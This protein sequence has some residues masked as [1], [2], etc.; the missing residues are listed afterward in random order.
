MRQTVRIELQPLGQTIEVEAGAPLREVLFS[1]GV[2]FP[3]GG[4]GRCKGCRVR[5]LSGTSPAT[6]DEKQMLSPRELSDG[7][8]L[9]CR[10]QAEGNLTL[11]IA[12]WE[13]AILADETTFS[14]TPTEGLGVAVDLGTTTLVAQLLDLRSGQVRA[15]QAG[16]N[17]QA[18][19]GSDVMSRVQHALSQHG[20]VQ[21]ETLIRR[22]IGRLLSRLIISAG[23]RES[24]IADVVI[25]GNTVMHH[26]FC[27]IPVEPL[28]HVPFEPSK[29][30]LEVF[31]AR[32]LG[33][34]LPGNPRVSFLPCVGGFVGSDLLAGV[35]A[36]NLH[37][38]H[39]LLALV[40]LGTNGEIVLG[41][42]ERLLCASTAAGPAFEAGRIS[43]GMR[44][45][46]G[47]I[48][49]VRDA[50][51]ELQCTVLGDVAA[52]GICGSGLVDAVAKALGLGLIHSNGRLA[53]GRSSLQLAPGVSLTQRDIRELQLAKA[54]IAA[55]MRILLDIWGA[56]PADIRRL[57]L[58]GAFGN[59]INR[60]SARRI[61]L[62]DFPDQQIKPAGNTA[63]LGAKISL[64][65][66]RGQDDEVARIK[67]RIEH[68][69]LA[70][71]PQFQDAF[72]EGIAF[73]SEDRVEG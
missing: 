25:V 55:G 36:T 34:D 63:L 11:Q 42:R 37:L 33:W 43:C 69:S 10:V 8:R 17:P 46:T 45:T 65:A 44:A 67:S 26:L 66:S 70:A 71:H 73:P 23:V 19:H 21:L 52:R 18:T 56:R 72:V 62:L 5:L 3:C 60:A 32:D 40:D 12:Q 48:T 57:Y 28:S 31:C 29:D 51:G 27:G 2:E 54:A 38:S 61:G 16:L 6:S 15:V 41:N 39:E 30:G 64:F 68:V 13:T 49:E 47:A 59:Y 24:T 50:A 53:G 22:E 20:R 7:W 9:A 58:S 35:L 4:H 1:R 14:F